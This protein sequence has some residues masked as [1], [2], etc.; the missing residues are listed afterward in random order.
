MARAFFPQSCDIENLANFPTNFSKIYTRKAII[1]PLF[2]EKPTNFD[3]KKQRMNFQ[4]AFKEFFFNS[5]FK[6]L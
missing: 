5:A 2:F 4:K 6:W 1:S 3:E